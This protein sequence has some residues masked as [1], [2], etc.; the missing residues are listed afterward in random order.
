MPTGII[1]PRI[2]SP[3]TKWITKQSQKQVANADQPPGSEY[4]FIL[5]NTPF[6]LHL[7]HSYAHRVALLHPSW[8]QHTASLLG[9]TAVA[10]PNVPEQG[11]LARENAWA[12][13]AREALGS[14]MLRAEVAREVPLS[15]KLPLA[16]EALGGGMLLRH[17]RQIV[18][19]LPEAGAAGLAHEFRTG[20]DCIGLLVAHE[21]VGIT[22]HVGVSFRI[23]II[24]DLFLDKS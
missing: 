14:A 22:R 7:L 10:S 3:V 12:E 13:V 6:Q 1:K 23:T 5:V 16:Q 20:N 17:V 2:E 15:P 9:C 11:G 4:V 8:R 19:F 18:L 24:L 21:A